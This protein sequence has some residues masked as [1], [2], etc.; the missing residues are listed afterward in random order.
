MP[1]SVQK[2]ENGTVI[3]HLPC[4]SGIKVLKILSDHYSFSYMFALI[5]NVPSKKLMKKD[6]VKI[7]Q[8]FLD[9]KVIDKISLVSP[10]ASLNII[11]KGEVVEKKEIKIPDIL[12]DVGKCPNPNCITNFERAKTE[13]IRSTSG[14]FRCKYCERIFSSRE[15]V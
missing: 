12:S 3:D 10:G 15:L 14:F 9:K 6:I 5:M 11:K 2:I 8:V 13:F 4:G 7:D 1:L